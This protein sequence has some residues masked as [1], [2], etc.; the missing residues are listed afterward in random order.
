MLRLITGRAHTGKTSAI[1]DEIALAVRE[2]RGGNMLIVPEQY[3]HEAERELCARCGDAMSLFAEV[4][5][6]TGL[7]RR[8]MSQQ[9]G[10]A[11]AWLDRGGRQ[12]CMALA[13]G[14]VGARLKVYG[15]SGRRV[16]LQSALLTAVDEFKSAGVTPAALLAAAEKSDGLL[17]GKLW[18]VALVTE[19]Y[20]AAVANGRADP[21]DRLDILAAQ[22]PESGIGGS[23]I[24]IDG[25]IDF[26]HQEQQVIRAMLAAGAEVTVCLTLD[27]LDGGSEVFTLSRIAARRL[28]ECAR[29]LGCP[30]CIETRERAGGEGETDFFAENMFSY[31][32]VVFPRETDRIR[33]NSAQSVTEECELAAARAIELVRGGCRWRD[34][35]VAVRGFE[36]YRRALESVFEHY[37]VPL[38]VSRKSEVLSKPIPALIASAYEIVLGGWDVDDVTGYMRTSLT[39]LTDGECDELENYIFKWQLRAPAWKRADDWRQHPDGFGGK[40]DA[41]CEERLGR[42]NALRRTLAGPLLRFERS[43]SMA[44]TA[45]AQ[46]AALSSLLLEL[47]LP[48]RLSERARELAAAGRESTAAEYAQ[49]WDITVSA[50]EQ[51]AA[52]LGDTPMEMEEFGRLF[53]LMLSKY[54]IGTIPVS[55]DRVSAGDFDRMRRRNIKHLIVLGASDGRLPAAEESG[56]VFSTDERERLLELDID[57][58]GA[59]ESGLWREFSLIYN[60]LSLPSESLTMSYSTAGGDGSAQ[61]PAFVMNRASALFGVPIVRADM[62]AVRA[63]SRNSALTLAALASRGG[64]REQAAAEYFAERE[65]QRLSA[66][67]R[68]ADMS[69][70]RLSPRAVE[71]LYGRTLRLSAS[72]IDRFAA[73]KFSYFCQYGL[74]AKKYEP[75]AFRPPEI[76]T[77][78]HAVLEYVARAASER[79]GFGSVGDEELSALVDEAV[80]EYVRRELGS[81]DEKSERFRHLFNRMRADVRQIVCDMADELRRSDFRPLDFE[82]DFSKATDIPP[83][84]LGEGEGELQLVG[85]ADRVD[86]WEHDGKLYIRIVD[87]KTGRKEFSLSDVWYGMGLQMLLYLFALAAD[88]G[89]RYGSEIVP[90]GIMYVPARSAMAAVD[91]DTDTEGIEKQLRRELR[92]SGLVLAD[93]ALIE[94]WEHGGDKIYIPLKSRTGKLEGESFASAERLGL[95]RRHIEKTLGDMARELRGGTISAD[96]YYRTQRETA[97]MNC[98]YFEACHFADGEAGESCRYMPKLGAEQVWTML[99]GGGQNG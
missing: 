14:Q 39:G 9:G 42:I 96:P 23:R 45:A 20:D 43:G 48:E 38:F 71:A 25:F 90:A 91:S 5:S 21:S 83:V 57:I 49:L 82:L 19:A 92:R 78:I 29:E 98:D 94:A 3:S 11:A 27:G 22:L 68:A 87:Y 52:V 80:E 50:L 4:F 62:T 17:S 60:C 33:L 15:A 69:R 12:L 36:E 18:D 97:C 16:E 73:C 75:A 2:G 34:I 30:V 55:L 95:L 89:G 74:K 40:F 47:E 65:P 35:A 85:I 79:G 61:R 1:M 99:E 46:A 37:G 44:H 28:G 70:G 93:D 51:S 56:G 72:R 88:G 76:G 66:L 63:Q 41:R 81:F 86:G 58:G 64:A 67:E 10:A 32:R 77:F 8:V 13:L 53:T 26:T 24:Y 54:E 6:F 59:G 84:V 31:A 7:A